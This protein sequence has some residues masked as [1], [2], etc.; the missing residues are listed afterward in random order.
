MIIS[1]SLVVT[2]INVLYSPTLVD[3]RIIPKQFKGKNL[4]RVAQVLE[5][6]FYTGAFACI[7]RLENS[8]VAVMGCG[9]LLIGSTLGLLQ[10][11]AKARLRQ[12][13][14]DAGTAAGAERLEGGK[15]WSPDW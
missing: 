11:G 2:A 5:L 8:D 15:V 7:S 6:V 3:L 9:F 14:W 4:M 10:K 1:A 12:Q 13:L